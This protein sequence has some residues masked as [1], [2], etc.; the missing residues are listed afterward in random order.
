[1]DEKKTVKIL[2]FHAEKC[3][4]GVDAKKPVHKSI[5]NLMRVAT[6]Q[7]YES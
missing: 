1:M 2:K 7:L 5:L 3:E 4:G 6:S